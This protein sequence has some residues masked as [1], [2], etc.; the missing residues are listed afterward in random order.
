MRNQLAH[1]YF[2]VNLDIVWNTVRNDLPAL[3]ERLEPLV[4]DM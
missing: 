4:P 1:G 2:S 3:L